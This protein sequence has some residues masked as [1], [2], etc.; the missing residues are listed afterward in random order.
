LGD[1]TSLGF[2]RREIRNTSGWFSVAL[3]VGVEWKEAI[4]A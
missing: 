1:L 2:V 3:V 4:A